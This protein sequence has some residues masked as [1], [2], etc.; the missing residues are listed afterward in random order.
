MR[1]KPKPYPKNV[2]GDFYV[3]D[4]CCTGCM[5]YDHYAPDLVSF[6]ESDLHCFIAK[7]PSDENELFQAVKITWASEVA[8]VRYGGKNPQIL[9]RLAEAGLADRC[10]QEHLVQEIKPVLRNHVTF[11]CLDARTESRI[12]GQFKD[13]LLNQNTEYVHYKISKTTE[14]E[15]GLT[16]SYSWFEDNYYAVWFNRIESAD[17][18]HIFHS[19]EYEKMGSRGVSMKIDEWLR[20]DEKMFNIKWYSNKAWNNFFLEWQETP[21]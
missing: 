18:W 14:N 15:L 8:C 7:Q 2:E 13:F 6:D 1:E 5:V 9:R 12:A 11:E 21:I 10:D 17:A 19:P 20:S 4:G 16:F 3:E